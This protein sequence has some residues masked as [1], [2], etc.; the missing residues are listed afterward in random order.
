MM[1]YLSV[2]PFDLHR[3][4]MQRWGHKIK[5][6]QDKI[7]GFVLLRFWATHNCNALKEYTLCIF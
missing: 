2:A 7:E 6:K 5:K 3:L 1:N 4:M